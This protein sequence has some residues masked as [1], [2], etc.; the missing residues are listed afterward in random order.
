MLGGCMVTGGHGVGGGEV[1]YR[2][3]RRMFQAR[4]GATLSCRLSVVGNVPHHDS[5]AHFRATDAMREAFASVEEMLAKGVNGIVYVIRPALHWAYGKPISRDE[6]RLW[7][8]P[9]L[10]GG[11]RWSVGGDFLARGLN[12]AYGRLYHWS[13]GRFRLRRTADRMLH[14]MLGGLLARCEAARVPCI[15]VKLNPATHGPAYQAQVAA[16]LTE[17]GAGPLRAA[18]WIDPGLGDRHFNAD[19]YHVNAEGHRMIAEALYPV[20]RDLPV[21]T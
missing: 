20:L 5:A 3:L 12:R 21:T 11:R 8:H 10:A 19:R 9:C 14:E 6:N 7:L 16:L 4:D 1:F 15:I 18:V 17:L 2:E 13:G